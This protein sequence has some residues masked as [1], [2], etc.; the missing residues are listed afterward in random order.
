MIEGRN[1]YTIVVG[2]FNTPFSVMNKTMIQKISKEIENLN[3]TLYQQT[4][5]VHTQ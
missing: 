5:T 2:D 3:N 1:F 4:Y